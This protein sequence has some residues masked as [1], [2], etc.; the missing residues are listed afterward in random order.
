MVVAIAAG[1]YLS[2]GKTQ[3]YTYYLNQAMAYAEAASLTSDSGSARDAWAQALDLVDHAESYKVTDDT[4]QVREWA[5]TSLDALDGVV[6]LDYRPALTNDLYA[7][8]EITAVALVNRDLYLL[9]EAGGR[10]I[11]ANQRTNGYEIDADFVC[12]AGNFTGGSIGPLVD[13]VTLPLLNAF[14]AHVL[15]VD[16][17]GKAIYCAAGQDPAVVALP[18]PNG[19]AGEITAIALGGG[20]LYVLSPAAGSIR[21]YQG[22]NSR[23]EET[24][25]EYF[26]GADMMG[27]PDLNQVTDIAVNGLDLYLLQ[28]TGLVTD[29]VSSSVASNP[30][31]CENPVAY[32]DGGQGWK[33]NWWLMPRVS[34]AV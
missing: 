7:D 9:D 25:T 14:D 28:G 33:N 2:R 32:V 29:C 4:A 6:R 5:Q 27:I 1:V 24:P 8:I 10:V 20:D 23:F 17:T 26:E 16:A 13:M 12:A 18:A 19:S 3:Q 15:A 22:I 31:T 30:V 11:H 21:V 34:L